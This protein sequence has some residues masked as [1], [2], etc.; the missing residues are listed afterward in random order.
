MIFRIKIQINQLLLLFIKNLALVSTVETVVQ[1]LFKC[2]IKEV[3]SIF[4]ILQITQ[5]FQREYWIFK[6]KIDA[7]SIKNDFFIQ[8]N[9]IKLSQ[10]NDIILKLI[11]ILKLTI[12]QAFKKNTFNLLVQLLARLSFFNYLLKESTCLY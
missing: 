5:L 4:K 3:Q 9:S 6:Y 1:V 11:N 10:F 7:R 12:K 2:V 8:V